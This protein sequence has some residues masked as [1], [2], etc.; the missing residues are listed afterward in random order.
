M[1]YTI[2]RHLILY[3]Y[4]TG[5]ISQHTIT[6]FANEASILCVIQF[7]KLFILLFSSD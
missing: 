3:V 7:L 1:Y 5:I 6:S 2:S 4:V